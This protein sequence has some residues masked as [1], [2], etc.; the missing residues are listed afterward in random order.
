VLRQAAKR[1][2]RLRSD[3]RDRGEN[4]RDLEATKRHKLRIKAKTLR[5]AMEFFA[6]LFP[7]GDNAKRREAALS[8]LKDMQDELGALNDLAQREALADRH[9][10]GPE[11]AK[12]L[13]ADAHEI[14]RRLKRAEA[15][16]DDFAKAK[17]F[18]T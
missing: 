7:D 4:L 8:S 16:F 1:L 18:W 10:L 9:D 3:V 6:G 15:A 11:A 17:P 2:T 13:A 5:Y 14:E 12:L